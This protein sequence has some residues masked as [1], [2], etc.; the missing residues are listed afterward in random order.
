MSAPEVSAPEFHERG[1]SFMDYSEVSNAFTPGLFR[2]CT[3]LTIPNCTLLRLYENP[4]CPDPATGMGTP[5]CDMPCL[6]TCAQHLGGNAKVVGIIISLLFSTM[7]N[8]GQNMMR[9][10]NLITNGRHVCC[11]PMWLLGL[12]IFGLGNA[13]IF[14]AFLCASPS[15]VAP[16]GSA[17]LISNNFIAH[18]FLG[19]A[20][21]LWDILA[22]ILIA[23]GATLTTVFGA[24]DELQL[25]T[26]TLALLF[27][28][29][30][31]VIF[32]LTLCVFSIVSIICM[33]R[34]QSWREYVLERGCGCG[35]ARAHL[36]L[37]L[38]LRACVGPCV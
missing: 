13:G 7:Q 28:S 33:F 30:R 3:Y 18:L 37:H 2:N 35:C 38:H 29:S 21:S 26:Y 8:L 14:L 5:A 12:F 4:E 32:G 1:H 15:V 16:L 25:D 24:D 27:S 36:H 23:A 19:E 22:T 6:T 34:F 17:S 31:F 11:T 10:G 20:L 9:K